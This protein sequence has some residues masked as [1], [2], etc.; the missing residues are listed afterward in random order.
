MVGCWGFALVVGGVEATPRHPQEQ[1]QP[2]HETIP[3][4]S[5]SASRTHGWLRLADRYQ[6]HAPANRPDLGRDASKEERTIA[7]RRPRLTYRIFCPNADAASSTPRI[8]VM[9]RSSRMG[10]TSTR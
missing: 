6:P 3:H 9:L 10:F 8:A 4:P 1:K 2:S 7:D 5:T